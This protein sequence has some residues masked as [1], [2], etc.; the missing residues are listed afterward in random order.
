MSSV[1][2]YMEGDF[3]PNLKEAHW[4]RISDGYEYLVIRILTFFSAH[5]VV[6]YASP[7]DQQL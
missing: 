2:D 5:A 4:R 3:W 6:I 7:S 1:W